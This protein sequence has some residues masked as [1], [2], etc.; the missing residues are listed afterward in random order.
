MYGVPRDLERDGTI[1]YLG[2]TSG[3]I[4]VEPSSSIQGTESS[5]ST[6][7][8]TAMAMSLGFELTR[9]L[10]TKTNEKEHTAGE[11]KAQRRLLL[12]PG[13]LSTSGQTNPGALLSLH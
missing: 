2:Q 7:P 5:W 6:D 11:K 13:A 1:L 3:I 8:I 10:M 12:R 4:I 9:R